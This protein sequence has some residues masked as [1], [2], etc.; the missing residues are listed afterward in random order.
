MDCLESYLPRLALTHDA[1]MATGI[2]LPIRQGAVDWAIPRHHAELGRTTGHVQPPNI[3][4][5]TA[6]RTAVW[7]SLNGLYAASFNIRETEFQQRKC[8]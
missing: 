2:N 6:R 8:E 4:E 7:T 5:R 1:A 3:L